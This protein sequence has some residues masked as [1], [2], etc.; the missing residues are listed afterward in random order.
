[1]VTLLLHIPPSKAFIRA[2]YNH[3]GISQDFEALPS[4]F[5]PTLHREVLLGYV[6]EVKPANACQ[7]IAAPAP[8]NSSSVAFVALIQRDNCPFTTKVLHAQQAGY[9][10][11]IVHNVNS[12]ALVAM[13]SEKEATKHI[14]IPSVFIGESASTQLKRIFHYDQTA[15]I[16]LIPDCHWL[17]CWDVRYNCRSRPHRSRQGVPEPAS[18]CLPTRC[19]VV[20]NIDC[21]L[22]GLTLVIWMVAL[23]VLCCL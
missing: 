18:P 12:Q 14:H 2:V 1:M 6:V 23:Y 15:Y 11:A 21:L 4:H 19:H 9:Q 17:S 8:S 13:L 22:F 16:I 7:P 5:G 3:N 10:A 20:S